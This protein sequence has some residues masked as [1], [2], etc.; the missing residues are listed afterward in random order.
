M[1]QDK[2]IIVFLTIGIVVWHAAAFSKAFASPKGSG[3]SFQRIYEPREKAFSISVPRGWQH[4]GG[5][6]RV[7]AAQAGGPLNAMEAKCDLRF[8]RDAQGTVAFHILP[9]IVYAHAGIG[10]GFWGPGAI[11]QGAV[12]RPIEAATTHVQSVFSQLHPNVP[13]TRAVKIERLPGEI[14]SMEQGLAYTNQLLARIGLPQGG[15]QCD[16]AGG[17]FEYTEGGTRFR[18][19]I[20]TGVVDMKAAMTWKN[21]RTLVFRAP[22]AEFDH[23]RPVMDIMRFSIRFHPKWVLSEMQGQKERA[24]I[25]MKVYDEIRRIDREI[26]QKTAINR[27][28]IMNDNFLVLTGQEEFVNPHTHAVEMDTDA[29]KY[30]WTTPGGDVYYTNREAENPNIFMQ[31]TDY[32][33]TPIRKRRND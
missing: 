3:I 18:E 24:D 19:V 1:H 28:E 12:V 9:D 27:E 32:K 16:A 29:Y 26:I 30:R 20:L 21:T 4:H 5:I 22:A 7:N 17:V 13:S 31:R 8:Q 23:W 2:R 6:Y 33:R 10:G 15:F 11:Y 25:V 14:R